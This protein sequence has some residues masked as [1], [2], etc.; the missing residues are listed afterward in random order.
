M[1]R[2]DILDTEFEGKAVKLGDNHV[3]LG[4]DINIMEKD[5]AL[6]NI[7][8]GMGWDTN[9]FAGEVAD[10]D[11]SVFLL[12]REEQTRVNEDFV[13]YNQPET[14]DGAV[15]HTGDSRTGIG[16]GDDETVIIDL[17][18]VPFDISSIVFVCSVYKGA[19]KDQGLGLVRNTFIRL[20]NKDNGREILRFNLDEHFAGSSDTAAIVG[21]I[22]R[23]AGKWRFIPKVEFYPGGLGAVATQFGLNIISQ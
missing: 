4:D 6:R 19:E 5:P 11:L 22:N 21:Q 8:V 17:H 7:M 15:V 3:H 10:V 14:L 13:F 2:K 18:G 16:D 12:G 1:S 23:E 9:A 20:V